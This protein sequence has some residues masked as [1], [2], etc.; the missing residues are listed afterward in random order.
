MNPLRDLPEDYDSEDLFDWRDER[1]LNDLDPYP[2]M[3]EWDNPP[4]PEL[5]SDYCSVCRVPGQLIAVGRISRLKLL[6]T[7][8]CEYHGLNWWV[9]D[10]LPPMALKRY[11]KKDL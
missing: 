8:R 1:G 11:L 4:P 6:K 3:N 2:D 10:G 5:P 7:Y 9:R